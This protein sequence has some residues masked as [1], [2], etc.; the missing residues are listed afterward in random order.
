MARGR[1]SAPAPETTPETVKARVLVTGAFGV[2]NDLVE[3]T[4]DLLKQAEQTGQVDPHPDAVAYAA[5][6]K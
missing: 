3:L 4:P 1:A 6:L 5:S 2:I